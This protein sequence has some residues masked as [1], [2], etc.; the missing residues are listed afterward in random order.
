MA[1]IFRGRLTPNIQRN[2]ANPLE[3][4]FTL[5]NNADNVTIQIKELD[6]YRAPDGTQI[7][8]ESDDDLLVTFTGRIHH[9]RFEVNNHVNASNDAALPTIKIKFQGSNQIYD[10]PVVTQA[11]ETEGT[12]WE[13]AFTVQYAGQ[14]DYNSPVSFITRAPGR[15]LIIDNTMGDLSAYEK[16][17]N[18]IRH[19]FSTNNIEA[20][21]IRGAH[22]RTA[23]AHFSAANTTDYQ[24]GFD[25]E[26]FRN[27]AR[28]Y[29][30]IYFNCH[31]DINLEGIGFG[32]Q[33]IPCILCE[34]RFHH[35]RFTSCNRDNQCNRTDRGYYFY[36]LRTS[37]NARIRIN[38]PAATNPL[39]FEIG[40][41]DLQQ[42]VHRFVQWNEYEAEFG[43]SNA[44]D[45]NVTTVAGPPVTHNI[46]IPNSFQFPTIIAFPNG[47]LRPDF[48]MDNLQLNAGVRI[49]NPPSAYLHHS[50][51][52]AVPGVPV[53][54]FE[55]LGSQLSAEVNVTPNAAAGMP[56][57]P[58][59]GA[60]TPFEPGPQ[61]LRV[62]AGNATARLVW[63]PVTDAEKYT[64]YRSTTA[65]VTES[66][67]AIKDIDWNSYDDT[68][69]IN[70]QQYFYRVRARRFGG[71]LSPDAI[72]A[73]NLNQA[74]IVYAG[75]CLT[76]RKIVFAENV[77]NAG[78][79]YFIGHQVVTAGNAEKLINRFWQRWLRNGANLR[80]VIPVFNRAVLSNP[81]PYRRT[82]PVIY[83]KDDTN[84]T[85]FWR[86]GMALPSPDSID[87]S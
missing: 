18:L 70:G 56:A 67:H 72:G 39:Q 83:Y 44:G 80:N 64:L 32:D 75:C 16:H 53:I 48:T 3:I 85:R 1:I 25:Y 81:G 30:Y 37:N 10:I 6:T 28:D 40:D 76:G 86:P 84:T 65:G 38:G 49:Q 33:T 87:I 45:P 21:I 5:P 50:S 11:G 69:L 68:G 46:T 51:A 41:W 15:A 34:S 78:A 62:V 7:N 8:E 27:A 20:N 29:D 22:S 55:G 17:A 47:P 35:Q 23:V 79:K 4:R 12:N 82:R 63:D 66:S 9:R 36:S 57:V 54:C 43:N 42:L 2:P 52:E 26:V 61:N 14:D 71:N 31:G 59:A 19:Y 24:D 58:V 60:S 73:T 77:L 13:V 74:K